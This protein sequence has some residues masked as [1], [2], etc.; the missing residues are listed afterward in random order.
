MEPLLD[1]IREWLIDLVEITT[2]VSFNML[3]TEKLSDQEMKNFAAKA[4]L[5]NIKQMMESLTS[6]SL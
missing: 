1:D 2:S 6:L 4:I 3:K 5:R